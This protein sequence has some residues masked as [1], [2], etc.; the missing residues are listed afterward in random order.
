MIVLWC[1]FAILYRRAYC[2]LMDIW[3]KPFIFSLIFMET[4]RM[5]TSTLHVLNDPVED[6]V[7]F[8][9]YLAIQS[10]TG[11]SSPSSSSLKNQKKY[12]RNITG[13][14]FFLYFSKRVVKEQKKK[15]QQQ[16]ETFKL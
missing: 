10:S 4:D 2:K 13:K 15:S 5:T 16:N 11:V 7:K 14:S 9:N 6:R 12:T 8:K 3:M 1:R